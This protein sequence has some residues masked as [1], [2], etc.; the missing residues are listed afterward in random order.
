M[1]IVV[2]SD[3]HGAA[4][5]LRR[6][7]QREGQ[8]VLP[9]AF[10][11]CGDGLADMM[12]LQSQFAQFVPVRGNC[13]DALAFAHVPAERQECLAGTQVLIVHGHLYRVKM[14]RSLLVY[15][16]REQEVQAVFFGHTHQPMVGWEAGILLVNPGCLRQG[17][18]AVAQLDRQKP[19]TVDLRSVD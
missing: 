10:V 11:F 8:A 14:T 5:M 6:L 18:Y 12:P 4:G 13:D 7:L 3:S 19:V 16:A 17:Q 1:R 15:H 9:E 2:C